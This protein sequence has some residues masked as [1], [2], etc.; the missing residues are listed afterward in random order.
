MVGLRTGVGEKKGRFPFRR[1]I[2]RKESKTSAALSQFLN[3]MKNDSNLIPS[4]DRPDLLEFGQSPESLRGCH[5]RL[6]HLLAPVALLLTFV[7]S[8]GA[9]WFSS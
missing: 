8:A 3:P 1:L 9:Y 4:N 6:V 2:Y 7:A 5:A